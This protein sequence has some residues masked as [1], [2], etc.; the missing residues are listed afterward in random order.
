MRSQNL[1]FFVIQNLILQIMK[2][3]KLL[4]IAVLFPFFTFAQGGGVE[5][6]PFVGYMFGGSVNFYEGKLDITDGMDYGLSLIVPIRD[7]L[8]VEINYTGMSSE[9]RFTAYRDYPGYSDEKTA[10]STNY[11]QI[12]VLKALS[13]NNPK[14]KPFG[15]LSLGA[16]LFSLQDY[17]DT[18]RFS[19]A[20]GLGVKFMFTNHIGIMIRG[21]LLMPMSFGGVGGYCG[22]GTGGSSCGLSLNG[23]VQPL[24][25]DFNAG[26]IIKI[27]N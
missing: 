4:L 3:I 9:A 7:V 13:L 6:V 1:R 15:S 21:R 22:I 16:T 24:Q 20:L 5:I 10:I 17:T 23:Y 12:G 26:L 11:F 18:W 27:G 8:D 25:G 14:I 2:K 19:V